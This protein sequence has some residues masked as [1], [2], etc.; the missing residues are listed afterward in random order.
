MSDDYLWDGS[1]PEDKDVARLEQLLAPLAYTEV[2]KPRRRW[3]LAGALVAA[4]AVAA[5][6]LWPRASR[7]DGDGF[8]FTGVGGTVACGSREL[9]AGV[10]PVGTTLDTQ[11][12]TA[13]LAIAE[14]GTAQL[15]AHTRVR[16]ERTGAE[17][18]Q[19]YLERGTMHAKVTAP[20][21]L[22]SVST[23][24]TEVT[25][26]GCE[27]AIEVDA[28]GTGTIHVQ[29]GKVELDMQGGIVVAPA[30]THAAIHPGRRPGYPIVDGADPA[31]AAAVADYERGVAGALDRMLATATAS[32]AITLINLVIIEPGRVDVLQRLGEITSVPAGIT[33]DRAVSDAGARSQW[34]EAVVNTQI[35]V[36]SLL[37]R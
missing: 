2:R 24:S 31:F 14:I 16:L 26:L 12:H 21:R 32:D 18:H 13:E 9:A 11:E 6:A 25:D 33:V 17:R 29:A 22:F 28:G 35:H 30:G 10:L 5:I 7:C 27:Y 20:P 37:D 23:P 19:L 3:W 4:A 1:G 34:R 8:R 15:G 36:D